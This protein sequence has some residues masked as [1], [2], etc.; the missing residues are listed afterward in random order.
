MDALFQQAPTVPG[1]EVVPRSASNRVAS[2][3]YVGDVVHLDMATI[4]DQTRPT[5]SEGTAQAR[6]WVEAWVRTAGAALED[7][8]PV[9]ITLNGEP[10]R[11]PGS[12]LST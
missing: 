9:L 12:S 8:S 10:R 2:L 3:T 11:S 6:R 5:G 7:A 4:D 1:A